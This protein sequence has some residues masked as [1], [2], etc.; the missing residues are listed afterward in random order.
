MSHAPLISE[1]PASA[2]LVDTPRK[3]TI[4]PWLAAWIGIASFAALLN[5]GLILATG[6]THG[7][8]LPLLAVLM[9]VVAACFDGYCGR[10]PNPLTYTGVLVGLA[11]NLLIP[12]LQYLHADAALVWLGAPGPRESLLA[13]GISAAVVLV[14]LLFPHGAITGIGT[15]DVKLLAAVSAMIGLS[16]TCTTAIFA[17]VIALAYSLLNLVALGQL[18]RVLQIGGQRALELFFFRRFH[19]PAP[20]E[21]VSGVKHFPMSIPLALG[22]AAALWTFIRQGHKGIFW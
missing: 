8:L 11:I 5:A 9:C 17:L 4:V 16:L 14:M 20:D 18:N 1:L 10:I 3:T 19:T 21:P 12:P 15:G 7:Y 6:G 22:I 2:S 13:F